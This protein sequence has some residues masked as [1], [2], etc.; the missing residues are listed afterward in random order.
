MKNILP[1][2]CGA[3]A[4]TAASALS[5]TKVVQANLDYWVSP[6]TFS[7]SLEE[8]AGTVTNGLVGNV[9]ATTVR[10]VSK[11][12]I[13]LFTGKTLP[14][15]GR[16]MA[17]NSI[18]ITD[19]SSSVTNEVIGV[20]P[21]FNSVTNVVFSRRA[22]LLVKQPLGTNVLSQ[23]GTNSPTLVV[24][25]DGGKDYSISDFFQ[26][27]LVS[28]DGRLNNTIASGQL[29]LTHH[30]SAISVNSVRRFILDANAFAV[31]P[32]TGT[33][34][35]VQG[36][37]TDMHSSITLKSAI[38]VGDFVRSSTANVAGTGQFGTTNSFALIRGS[39]SWTGGKRELE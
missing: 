11:D 30:L 15:L 20:Y 8:S 22:Q 37:A 21:T 38:V 33:Y 32:P 12:F 25:R 18:V 5:Q 26:T 10:W 27:S 13:G 16:Q 2:L 17:T 19:K 1:S 4:L 28:F 3:L 24:I 34:F 23:F 31:W 35:D 29:D 7:L 9:K 39:I 36:Y 6:L 14:L